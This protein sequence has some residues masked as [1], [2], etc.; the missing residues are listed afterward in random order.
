MIRLFDLNPNLDWVALAHEF[1]RQGRLQVRDLLTEESAHNSRRVLAEETPWSLA[2]VAG[3]EKPQRI[4]LAELSRTPRDQ[5]VARQRRLYEAVGR[6][7]YGFLF[8]QFPILDAYKDGAL[9]EGPHAALLELI[10]DEPFLS[11]VRTITGLPDLVKADAQATLFGPGQ[12]LG[13]HDDSHVAEGWRVAYV[14][15][16]CDADWHPDWGGYLSFYDEDGDIVC[17]YRP[18]FNALNLFL[19]PQKHNVSYVPPFA[20]LARY[21]VTGWFRDR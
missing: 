4:S 2:V 16:L 20:P 18:R 1:Q 19:V 11:L 10:N 21:S 3:E 5:L 9:A 8:S 14:L 6:G 7:E 12:F 15:N 13:L 17:G